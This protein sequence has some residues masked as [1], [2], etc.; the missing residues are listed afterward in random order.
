MTEPDIQE[1]VRRAEVLKTCSALDVFA[2]P[3]LAGEPLDLTS[4]AGIVEFSPA[5]QVVVVDSGTPLR[6]L[7]AELERSGQTIPHRFPEA[8][9]DHDLP[10][11][12]LLD[13]SLPHLLEAQCG[14]WR[15]WV[16]GMRVVLADGSVRVC[17]SKA[18]K[19]VAGYD[20]QKLFIGARGSLGLIVQVTLRTYPLKA[21]PEPDIVCGPG[22]GESLSIHRSLRTRFP[23]L[24]KACGEFLVCGD[25][26]TSTVWTRRGGE[27]LSPGLA[28]WTLQSGC[29]A[30]NLRIRDASLAA[31][32]KRAKFLF[33]PL[34]KLNPGA[35]GVC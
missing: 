18:V 1:K 5:D 29:G 28:E 35:M 34:G 4:H 33:D 26:A 27:A 14:S 7:T 30:D 22:S 8:L 3:A 6:A 20:V 11:H 19:N 25:R 10:L 32:M 2:V 24:I 13:Y 23:E 15:D 21:L 9:A 12:A 16:L 31:L 17:G